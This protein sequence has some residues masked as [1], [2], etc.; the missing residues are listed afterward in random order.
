MD[1]L[2]IRPLAEPP[3]SATDQVFD[4]LYDAVISLRLPPGTKVSEAEVA[5]Q[6]GVSRQPVRDAF[7]RL[8]KLG[9]I[10]I[11]PQRATL[12]TKISQAAVLNAV[13]TRVA[14]EAEC[15]RLAMAGMTDAGMATLRETLEAQ[16]ASLEVAAPPRFPALDDP[17]H[18]TICA[19]AGHRHAWSLIQEQKAHMDRIRFLTLSAR[20]QHEVMEE[21]EVIVDA[22]EAGQPEEAEARLRQHIET[23]R[24]VL[25]DIRHR[26][27]DHVEG[28]E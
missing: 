15:L 11:R 9:F 25:A 8:S 27:P 20:R 5:K 14:L 22:I 24:D 21:H 6:M 1:G 2:A 12:I 19:L 23:I 17:F 7:F 3:A 4:A 16:R 26:H 28:A 18:E 10:A 13:F